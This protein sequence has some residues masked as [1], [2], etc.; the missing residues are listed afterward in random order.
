MANGQ[1]NSEQGWSTL[2]HT[3]AVLI[4]RHLAR[5]SRI[6]KSIRDLTKKAK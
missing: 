6:R 2:T 3:W 1:I 4:P 5:S